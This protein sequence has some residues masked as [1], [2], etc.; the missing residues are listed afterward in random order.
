MPPSKLADY[1]RKIINITSFMETKEDVKPAR[2]LY[3]KPV[4]VEEPK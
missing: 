3:P 4:K 2:I 1:K